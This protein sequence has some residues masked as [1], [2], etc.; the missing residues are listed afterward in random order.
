MKEIISLW[1]LVLFVLA[2]VWKQ[3]D[4]HFKVFDLDKT[5]KNNEEDIRLV[6]KD[7]Y[8]AIKEQGNQTNESIKELT[9][10]TSALVAATSVMASQLEDLRSSQPNRKKTFPLNE[11][12]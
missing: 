2:I 1:P 6:E 8:S 7:L 3:I 4:T 11:K 5:T 10:A 9:K 12:S